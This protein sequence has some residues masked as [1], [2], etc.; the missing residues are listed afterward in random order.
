MT[1]QEILQKY[2]NYDSFRHGQ[3][4]IIN[5][6]LAKKPCLVLMPTGSGKSLC[7]QVP[8]LMFEGGTLVI[9]PLIALMQD[10]ADALR[11]KNIP[12]GFINSTLSKQERAQRLNQFVKGKIKLLYV[13]PER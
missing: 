7:Y 3:E 9:S 11:R 6:V 13:T 2:F 4:E 8:A 5:H 10:Q 1:P 12:A